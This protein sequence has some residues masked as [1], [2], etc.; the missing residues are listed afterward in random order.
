MHRTA[1]AQRVEAG[2]DGGV[3]F[4]QVGQLEDQGAAL[5]AGQARPGAAGELGAR[6]AHRRIDLGGAAGRHAGDDFLARRIDDVD[7]TVAA[8]L[9]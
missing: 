9:P 8:V 6:R 4:D 5:G 1:D 7:M 2:D 3:A